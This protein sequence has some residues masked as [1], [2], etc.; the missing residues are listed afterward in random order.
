MTLTMIRDLSFHKKLWQA[1]EMDR[2]IL[3]SPLPLYVRLDS[4]MSL[5]GLL[6]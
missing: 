3:N 1:F 6:I 2:S 4:L 5:A